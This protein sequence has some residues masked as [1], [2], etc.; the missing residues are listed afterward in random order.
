MLIVWLVLSLSW[1]VVQTPTTKPCSQMAKQICNHVG[2]DA[3]FCQVY[4]KLAR[5]N[6]A[7]QKKCSKL[8]KHDWEQRLSTLQRQEKILS[9]MKSMAE[10]NVSRMGQIEAY[11]KH[12]SEKTINSMLTTADGKSA[13]MP[14]NPKACYVL[15]LQACRDL[16][17]KAFYCNLFRMARRSQGVKPEKCQ[18]ILTHWFTSQKNHYQKR[19][20]VLK[21]LGLK[22]RTPKEIEQIKQIKLGQINNLMG[23][24]RN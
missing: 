8:M 22:A 24:L 21:E 1:S 7:D 4:V 12:L 19:E 11:Q 3:F 18:V 14:I 9:R 13:G 6:F 16:G 20:E 2:F 15:A 5:H 23:F 10:G 17:A